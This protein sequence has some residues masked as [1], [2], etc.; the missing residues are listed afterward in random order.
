MNFRIKTSYGL[1][2]F[3]QRCSKSFSTEILKLG[4]FTRNL[5]FFLLKAQ[6]SQMDQIILGIL[7]KCLNL[8]EPYSFSIAILMFAIHGLTSTHRRVCDLMLSFSASDDFIW[9]FLKENLHCWFIFFH[10]LVEMPFQGTN[11]WFWL[12]N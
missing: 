12:Q 2:S 11:F 10:S 3:T 8:Q 7:S 6:G 1:V 5:E 4:F 9:V